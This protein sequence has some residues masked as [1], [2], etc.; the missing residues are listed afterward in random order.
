MENTM[1]DKKPE[2]SP[3]R[4]KRLTA[5]LIIYPL[6]LA[7]VALLLGMAIIEWLG[8]RERARRSHCMSNIHILGIALQ[9]YSDDNKETYSA[10]LQTLYDRY[11]TDT[12]IYVCT[13]SGKRRA[14]GVTPTNYE[15][16]KSAIIPA[17]NMS[18]CYV[19][20]LKSTDPLD[21]VLAFE[22]ET[23][24]KGEGINVL[25]IGLNVVWMNDIKVVHELLRKQ[26]KELKAQ[27]REMRIIRPGEPDKK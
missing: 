19:A 12:E 9:M 15:L 24:H 2:S 4:R 7:F 26:E 13:S 17:K 11:A 20:G 27:G 5:R 6:A 21:Y 14:K 18:Y 8:A 1:D 3:P 16:H 22:E 25:Y 10:D 23:D